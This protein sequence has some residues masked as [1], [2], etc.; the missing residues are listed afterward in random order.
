MMRPQ[1]Q[2]PRRGYRRTRLERRQYGVIQVRNS[3]AAKAFEM[4]V[5]FRRM[6]RTRK[7]G[8]RVYAIQLER[9][10]TIQRWRE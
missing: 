1:W 7:H 5:E 9:V 3:C 4:L 2:M 8:R 10:L 6:R